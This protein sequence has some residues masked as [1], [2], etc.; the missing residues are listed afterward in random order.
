[1]AKIIFSAM[2]GDRNSLRLEQFEAQTH[3]QVEVRIFPWESAWDEL[4]SISLHNSGADVSHIGNTWLGS[5]ASMQSLQPFREKDIAKLGGAKI[6][7]PNTWETTN[8]PDEPNKRYA[9]P[10]TLDTR[11]FLYRRDWL[12]KAGIDEASAF[13]NHEALVNTLSLLQAAGYKHPW[14]VSMIRNTAHLSAPW[15]WENGG[16]FRAPDLRN[17]AFTEPATLRGLYQ[18]FSLYRFALPVTHGLTIAEVADQFCNEE[19]GVIYTTHH[20]L[21]QLLFGEPPA[22]GIENVGAAK[23]PGNPYLG[24]NSLVIWK[25]SHHEEAALELVRH[26]LTLETQR[27]LCA[28]GDQLPARIDALDQKPFKDQPL[29]KP[30]VESL[31]AGRPFHSSYHWA[32]IEKRL[33]VTLNQLWIDLFANPKLDLYKELNQ[34]IGRFSERIQKTFLDTR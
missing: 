27:S 15:V 13:A 17:L 21:A 1:M 34:R 22:F 24:G 31:I 6:F 25:H 9:I 33:N 4:L 16:D 2:F 3:H 10:W 7:L 5:L 30:V 26:L 14:S 29:M 19:I 20:L 18:F 12:Q 32:T 11:I 23:V 8:L 28:H